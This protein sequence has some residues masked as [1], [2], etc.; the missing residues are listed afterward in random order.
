[1]LDLFADGFYGASKKSREPGARP[2]PKVATG[3]PR[4]GGGNQ[5]ARQRPGI[6]PAFRNKPFQPFFATKPTR[7]ATAFTE[8][9]RVIDIFCALRQ[10][11]A[12]KIL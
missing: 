11:S 6:P 3:R 1:L 4:R 12:R 10:E 7:K 8:L 9:I 2:V 5:D